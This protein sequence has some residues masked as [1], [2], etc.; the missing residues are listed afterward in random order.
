MNVGLPAAYRRYRPGAPTLAQCSTPAGPCG[1]PP[2]TQKNHFSPSSPLRATRRGMKWAE[3]T[4]ALASCSCGD[5]TRQ[6]RA[7]VCSGCFRCGWTMC[8][9]WRGWGIGWRWWVARGL[10]K[11]WAQQS[12]RWEVYRQLRRRCGPTLTSPVA[13]PGIGRS[14]TYSMEQWT[15]RSL[16]S[17]TRWMTGSPLPRMPASCDASM[18]M[19]KVIASRPAAKMARWL[20]GNWASIARHSEGSPWAFALWPP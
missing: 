2:S 10:W 14:R 4:R 1:P 11:F 17:T 3:R 19:R 16:S 8:G 6:R 18:S 15:G 5:G 7:R 12:R 13:W 9:R 20:F